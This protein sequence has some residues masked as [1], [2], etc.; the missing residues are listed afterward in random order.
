VIK[1]HFLQA[2]ELREEY[3]L[4]S[5]DVD[6]DKFKFDY[7]FTPKMKS[8]LES[9]LQRFTEVAGLEEMKEY[10]SLGTPKGPVPLRFIKYLIDTENHQGLYNMI[11]V[12]GEEFYIMN[13]IDDKRFVSSPNKIMLKNDDYTGYQWQNIYTCKRLTIPLHLKYVGLTIF[14]RS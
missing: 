2:A 8:I 1:S 7:V 11:R 12:L 14:R 10:D 13:D 4:L 5:T 9:K 6:M 3:S